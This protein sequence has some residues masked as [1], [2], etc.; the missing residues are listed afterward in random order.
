MVLNKQTSNLDRKLQ[1]MI[2]ACVKFV[3]KPKTLDTK[4]VFVASSRKFQ[5]AC[6]WWERWRDGILSFLTVICHQRHL[7]AHVCK[8]GQMVLSSKRCYTA[9]RFSMTTRLKRWIWLLLKSQRMRVL[10]FTLPSLKMLYDKLFKWKL[11]NTKFTRRWGR[12]LIR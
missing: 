9:L 12:C 7:W 3:R 6:T 10:G 2:D 11:T 8:R 4:K 5:F 1:F